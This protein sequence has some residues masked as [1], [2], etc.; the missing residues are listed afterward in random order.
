[1]HDYY[2]HITVSGT[3]Y[4]VSRRI[5]SLPVP[6]P[7]KGL[8]DTVIANSTVPCPAG[9]GRGEHR[10]RVLRTSEGSWALIDCLCDKTLTGCLD[11]VLRLKGS[12]CKTTEADGY[13][14]RACGRLNQIHDLNAW[15]LKL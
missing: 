3:R 10:L 2:P 4:W 9:P 13:L 5:K 1:M 7:G 14:T 8:G 12:T 15:E 6:L 11:L